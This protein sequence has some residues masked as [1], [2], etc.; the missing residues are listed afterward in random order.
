MKNTGTPVD[1]EYHA[2]DYGLFPS[3]SREILD[4]HQKGCLNAVSVMP[5]SPHLSA[6]MERLRAEG[7]DVK[8]TVHLNLI[9][10][11]SL[12]PPDRVSGLVDRHGVFTVSFGKLL[13]AH[14]LPGKRELGRQLCEELRAQLRAVQAH[15]PPG[16]KLRVDGHAHY[17][18]L[19]IVFDSLVQV[20]GEEGLEVE[21]IRFP[22]ERLGLYAR[23]LGR[24]EGVRL[25]NLVKV[26]VLKLLS[27]RN[28]RKHGAYL[29]PMEKRLFLGVALSGHMTEK[30]VKA[31][32]PGAVK[33]AAAKGW[34]IELLAHPGGVYEPGDIAALT[35]PDDVA[36]LTGD[37][38]AKE[39]EMFC[40]GE[41]EIQG[42]TGR[43]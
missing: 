30:N 8:I 5:N 43:E 27:A 36:F 20:L 31:L 34:G 17:H 6:C 9:E 40:S 25:I 24:L 15:M 13:L 10:G 23:V 21:Y 32:L 4:C 28:R 14:L 41:I 16:A 1:V 33:K 35:H 2:D 22:D 38:R 42:G 26:V 37:D 3:Q 29:A 18:M 7:A 39:K 11:H 12:C 19:P